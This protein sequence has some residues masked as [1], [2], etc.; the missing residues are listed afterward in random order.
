MVFHRYGMRFFIDLFKGVLVGI[1]NVIP[2]VSGGTMAV[3]LGIYDKMLS[4]ISNLL[5]EFKKSFMTLLPIIIGAAV[6][7]VLFSKA[8]EYL[9]GNH[10]LVTAMAFTGLIIGGLPIII[11]GM[12]DE[13]REKPDVKKLIVGIIVFLIFLAISVG[14]PLMSAPSGEETA[15]KASPL[16]FIIMLFMGIIASA[17]M[18]IPGV[19]GSLLMMILGFYF[20]II[21][22]I[23]HMVSSLTN[24][25]QGIFNDIMV[26]LPFG[27]GAILGIFLISKIIKWLFAKFPF[28][29]YCGIMGLVLSSPFAIFYKVN[30][31]SSMAGTGV[32]GI[33]IGI[34]V[35]L[36]CGGLTF[37]LGKLEGEMDKNEAPVSEAVEK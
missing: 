19:S 17:T 31:E 20:G 7:I 14:M 33:I 34:V 26:L 5:K 12:I 24:G 27:I 30:Q 15:I 13:Y 3:S 10:A 22:T 32:V 4:S 16:M 9:L 23:N 18:V 2:G 1:A 35:L 8:I 29:T 36:V 6:G 21:G 28:V 11:K 25:F 37:Y